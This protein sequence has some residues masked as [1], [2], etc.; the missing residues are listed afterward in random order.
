MC[1]Q[2][3]HQVAQKS[4]STGW[5]FMADRR[6]E[7]V[8]GQDPDPGCRGAGS[9]FLHLPHTGTP[10][11]PPR[12]RFLTPQAGQVT[13]SAMGF[14]LRA[15]P[16]SFPRR[17]AMASPGSVLATIFPFLNR[18]A[19]LPGKSQPDV[20]VPGLAR[21]VDLA[22]HDGHP[23][24]AGKAQAADLFFRRPPTRGIRSTEARAQVGQET[25]SM[26]L[27]ASPAAVRICRATR[28]SRTGSAV[29]ETRMVLPMPSRS[30]L[31]MPRAER[32]L[33]AKKEC[34]PRSR[35]GAAG[36]RSCGRPGGW[37]PRFP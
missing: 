13:I 28:I 27:R 20:G 2:G 11:M 17:R 29:S 8:R 35:P 12:T 18:K 4:T 14:L 6:F 21:A 10:R 3:W 24:A 9:G 25:M 1:R 15:V 33:P 31:P 36:R 26:P 5:G 30:R 37:R 22:A 34:R 23:Q 16:R 32:M 7:T 19:V